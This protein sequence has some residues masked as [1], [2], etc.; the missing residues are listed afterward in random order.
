[1]HELFLL[2]AIFLF[3]FIVMGGLAYLT[4]LWMAAREVAL[5]EAGRLDGGS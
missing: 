4:K 1:M 5:K 3:T 2:V